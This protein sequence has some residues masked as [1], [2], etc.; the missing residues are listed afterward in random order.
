MNRSGDNDDDDG[1]GSGSVAAGSS[2]DW[3]KG[4]DFGDPASVKKWV[5]SDDGLGMSRGAKGLSSSGS[6]FGLIP[7]GIQANDIAK[8]RGIRSYY[9]SIGDT[10]MVKYL[11][12]QLEEAMEKTGLLTSALDKLGLISGDS[13]FNQIES[14]APTSLNLQRTFTPDQRREFT[15]TSGDMVLDPSGASV[16][17]PGGIDVA[18]VDTS[19]DGPG[20]TPAEQHAVNMSRGRSAASK[21]ATEAAFKAGASTD[22]AEDI[23]DFREKIEEAG[24]TYYVGG[25]AEGGLMTASK[26][27]TKK[28]SPKKTGLAGKR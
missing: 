15:D 24:G 21:A 25:R 28:R 12:G 13:Y 26:R 10:E 18:M 11:D 6:I 9:E 19:D 23:K 14:F 16:Y 1:G 7:K 22:T 4:I 3:M 8:T 2:T 20:L 5:E 17:K 27:K